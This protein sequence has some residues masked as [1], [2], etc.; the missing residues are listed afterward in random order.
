MAV[1]GIIVVVAVETDAADVKEAA[2]LLAKLSSNKME[3]LV[4]LLHAGERAEPD[5]GLVLMDRVV[6]LLNCDEYAT[7]KKIIYMDS[8]I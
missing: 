1:E 6:T 8:T 5:L 7:R 3:I 2:E 4:L